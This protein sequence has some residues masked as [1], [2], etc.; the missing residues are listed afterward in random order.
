MC[1]TSLP[2]RKL[3]LSKCD[4]CKLVVAG[5]VPHRGMDEGPD[6][7]ADNVCPKCIKRESDRLLEELEEYENDLDS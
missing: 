2:D 6:G 7:L 4:W 3:I 5:C 1:S